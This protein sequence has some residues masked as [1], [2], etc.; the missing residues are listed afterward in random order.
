MGKDGHSGREQNPKDHAEQALSW[1]L[2]A[3]GCGRSEL[4]LWLETEFY[5]SVSQGMAGR[6]QRVFVK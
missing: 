4:R 2:E 1:E 6:Q 5:S 3:G